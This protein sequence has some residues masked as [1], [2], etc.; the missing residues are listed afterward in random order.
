VEIVPGT[1]RDCFFPSE[2]TKSALTSGLTQGD[3]LSSIS[4]NFVSEKIMREV[5]VPSQ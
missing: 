2:N 1:E 3:S 4:F 5:K